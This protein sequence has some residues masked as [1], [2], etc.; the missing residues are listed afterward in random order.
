MVWA[1]PLASSAQATNTDLAAPAKGAAPIRIGVNCPFSGGSSD[2]GESMRSA[3][4]VIVRELNGVGGIFGQ[5]V[6]LVERDD[7]ASP[8]IGKK[9]AEDL[10]SNGVLMTIGYCNSGVAAASIDVYQNAKVPLIIPVATGTQ[11]TLK[12]QNVEGTPNYI[13]RTAVPDVQQVDFMVGQILKRGL[14]KIAILAD[15]SGYGT[16]G[17]KDLQAELAKRNLKPVAVERFDVGVKDLKTELQRARAAGANVIFAYT[18]GPENAVISKSR[19]ELKWN[20]PHVGPWTVGFGNHLAA[21]G[22]AAEGS[23]MAQTFI[24]TASHTSDRESFVRNL[25]KEMGTDR[26][27]CAMCAAQ[28]YDAMQVA[29]RVIA[30]ARARSGSITHESV[31]RELEM[32]DRPVHGVVTVYE[33]PFTPKDH[34]AVSGNMLVLGEVRGGAVR[35]ANREDELRAMIPQR[36]AQ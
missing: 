23:L 14:D 5:P 32:L 25:H 1:A 33:Q 30:Q 8:D 10:V 17:L 27:P 11:L 26:I 2:M 15:N 13:F 6:E 35:F 4:R 12:F 3:M 22:A 24:E 34:D 20:V 29:L 19:A 7:Q 18:L 36:K 28:A 21:A 9:V 16:G 31:R